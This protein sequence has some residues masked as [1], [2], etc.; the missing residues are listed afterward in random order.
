MAKF[1]QFNTQGLYGSDILSLA[2]LRDD[3][4]QTQTVETGYLPLIIQVRINSAITLGSE[5]FFEAAVND[6]SEI[7]NGKILLEDEIDLYEDTDP[8][9]GKLYKN[10][11]VKYFSQKSYREI[12]QI[13]KD[14]G[15]TN[16]PMDYED[17]QVKDYLETITAD[18]L[19]DL[20]KDID[21]YRLLKQ[22]YVEFK[23]KK[24]DCTSVIYDPNNGRITELFYEEQ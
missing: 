7:E 18:N 8:T 14:V 19:D 3:Y 2:N 13:F 24:F 21:R 1:E 16:Y 10:R 23:S 12:A 22:L 5:T 9:T 17:Y 15:A 11:T 4:N 6:I 20:I